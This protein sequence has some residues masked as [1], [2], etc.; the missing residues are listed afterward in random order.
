MAPMES[1]HGTKSGN[2][3]DLCP[4]RVQ[5]MRRQRGK[6]KMP[7]KPLFAAVAAA[8]V[9]VPPAGPNLGAETG[10]PVLVAQAAAPTSMND[11]GFAGLKLWYRRPAAVWNE[12][13]PV[14]NGRLGAMVYG[15]I[16]EECL[17]LNEATVWTGGPYDPSNPEALKALPEVRRL[18]LAGKFREAQE[19]YGRR[20]MARP[21]NQQK[22]QPLGDLWIRPLGLGRPTDQNKQLLGY[23]RELDLDAAIASVRYAIGGVGY[24]REVFVTPV[25]QV[26]VVRLAADKPG[27][28][29]FSVRL[30]GRR[31][32]LTMDDTYARIS[33]VDGRPVSS[34]GDETYRVEGRGNDTLILTG[35]TATY[36]G[37]PGR[38][39]YEAWAKVVPE[40]GRVS[41]EG[42]A[43]TVVD[44][45]AATILVPA[46]TNFVSYKDLGADPAARVAAALNACAGKP[47]AELRDRHVT[48]HRRLFRRLALTLARSE[49][50]ELPTDERLRRFAAGAPDPDLAAL[51]FQFGRYLLV[52]S[53]R[54]GS[55]P[56]NLQG[57]WNDTM[58]PA[59]GSKYTTNINL[60]MNY[61]PAFVGNLDECSEPF[62][63]LV[64]GLADTGRKIARTHYGAR[65]WMLH[66]NTD[67]WL[68][69]APVNGPYVGTWP[70]G[71]AW[72]CNTLWD[73]YLFTSDRPYLERIY[74]LL[75]GAAEFFLDTLVVEPRHKWFVTCPSSSP[76]NWPHY[77]GNTSFSDEVRKVNTY[78]T[79]AAG[80]TIDMELLRGLFDACAEASKTLG[81]DAKFRRAVLEARGRLA[82][83]R[84]GRLG[85]LQ[86]YL[87]DWDD[88]KDTHRHLSHLYALYPGDAISPD[89]TPELAAAAR[90]SLLMRGEGGMGWSLAWKTALWARLGDGERS[91][92]SLRR[93][94][95][96][97][98]ISTADPRQGGTLPNLMDMGPPFQIDGNFGGAAGIAE[99][100]VQSQ[101]GE[102]FFLPAL[103][104]AWPR[105]SARGFGARG[106]FEVDFDWRDGRLVSATIRSLQGGVCRLRTSGP[107]RVARRGEGEVP[108]T[109]TKPGHVSFPTERGGVYVMETRNGP[110]QG[111]SRP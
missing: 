14:G 75:K 29:S 50:A 53:S 105:G 22:Y 111:P 41:L 95:E 49:N 40:G 55:V 18:V 85:Q 86:E 83:L 28:L 71:G 42:D 100:L 58:N 3:P 61:W 31:N 99:M 101:G 20:M 21:P 74:P 1:G 47:Y 7:V 70:C 16:A 35:R 9:L 68:A 19:L 72:L 12:A 78:A 57:I 91:Y 108:V 4:A 62:V 5:G 39:M 106:G 89:R 11:G 17:Q 73:R 56:A 52:C 109:E 30:T 84:I 82:P 26:I 6:A 25:G 13:L 102:I 90:T 97:V 107:V 45:D 66:H 43:V 103:P 104:A 110:G 38:V 76:E 37:I 51:Y 8:L 81:R 10:R 44:A 65:G 64:E 92:A 33:E 80:P 60:E 2:R 93:L 96:P 24:T 77:P 23:R 67:I 54:P 59:W 94:L 27:R 34:P 63:R 88:P 87:E 46:A 32:E 69:A 36:L 48:E 98:D 79:I 15:G